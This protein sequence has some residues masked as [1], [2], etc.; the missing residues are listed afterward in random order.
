MAFK[1]DV[2]PDCADTILN[3]YVWPLV[4]DKYGEPCD[5]VDL[6]VAILDRLARGKAIG[7]KIFKVTSCKNEHN[8]I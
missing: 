7:K 1:K 5:R 6:I 2:C 4:Y 8:K 3:V